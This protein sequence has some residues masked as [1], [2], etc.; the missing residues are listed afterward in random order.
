MAGAALGQVIGSPQVA[1][2]L[3][4]VGGWVGGLVGA[5]GVGKLGAGVGSGRL[6]GKTADLSAE[7]GAGKVEP[8]SADPDAQW[9]QYLP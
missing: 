4:D 1:S 5:D 3:G 2:V 7:P 9:Q 8:H 6:L